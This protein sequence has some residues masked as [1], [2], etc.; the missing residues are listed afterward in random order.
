MSEP[1]PLVVVSE[2]INDF[3]LRYL[4]SDQCWLTRREGEQRIKKAVW[5]LRNLIEEGCKEA[6]LR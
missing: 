4:A 3:S 2:E 1:S 5:A 6:G